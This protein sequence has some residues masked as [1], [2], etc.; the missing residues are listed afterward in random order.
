MG[1][2]PVAVTVG[3]VQR[4]AETISS[5]VSAAVLSAGLDETTVLSTPSSVHTK[6]KAAVV[7]PPE[8]PPRGTKKHDEIVVERMELASDSVKRLDDKYDLIV[9]LSCAV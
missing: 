7:T 2:S 9:S 5:D 3:A 4:Q 6:P 1:G 8:T